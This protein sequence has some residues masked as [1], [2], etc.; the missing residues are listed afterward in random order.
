MLILMRVM[1]MNGIGRENMSKCEMAN[2]GYCK[3]SCVGYCLA[4]FEE[5]RNCPYLKAIDEIAKLAIENSKLEDD[6][7]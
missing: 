2:L 5:I 7:K 3:K 6:L 4:E 1:K